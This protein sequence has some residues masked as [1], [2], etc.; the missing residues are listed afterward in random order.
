MEV[1]LIAAMTLDGYI[2]RNAEE[3]S[4]DWTTPEDKQVYIEKTKAAMHL[5]FGTTTLNSV[6]RFPK[7]TTCYVYTRNPEAF[8]TEGRSQAA[9]YEPTNES[10]KELVARLEK[11]GVQR[12]AI[13][14]G[15]S[16]Y[17]LFLAAGVVQK[18]ILT[19]EPVMFG[20][21]IP[22]FGSLPKESKLKL[23]ASTVLNE[24]GS[25]LLEYTICA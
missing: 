15:A 11:Q 1:F 8:S 25:V 3:R 9:T 19:L 12:L 13:C 21:G 22:L 7:G 6:H 4:F 14:G 23:D 10:P 18:I 16:I 2:G 17:N 5:V 24:Q 20:K